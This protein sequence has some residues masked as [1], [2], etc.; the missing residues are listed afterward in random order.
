[1]DKTFYSAN[2]IA[3]LLGCSA[4]NIRRLAKRG[5]IPHERVGTTYIFAIDAVEIARSLVTTTKQRRHPYP[6]LVGANT[7]DYLSIREVATLLGL[8][9]RQVWRLIKETAL[10][11]WRWKNVVLVEKSQAEA[12]QKAR[13]TSGRPVRST[14]ARV[15]VVHV[16]NSGAAEK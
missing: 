1:M 14:G 2:D 10:A 11:G 13:G 8:T 16:D 5:D 7:D 6:L 3:E 12:L 4:E 9:E 15:G